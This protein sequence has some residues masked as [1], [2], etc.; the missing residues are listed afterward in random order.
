MAIISAS[1]SS[2]SPISASVTGGGGVVYTSTGSGSSPISV[3]VQGGAQSASSS[4]ESSSTPKQSYVIAPEKP[5]GMIYFSTR[6]ETGTFGMAVR[7]S[8]GYVAVMWWDG[9]TNTYGTGAASSYFL[10]TKIVPTTSFYARSA[11]K[12]VYVWPTTSASLIQYGSITGFS[13]PGRK[14][15]AMSLAD[16]TAL[17]ALTVD[18]NLMEHLDLTR[19]SAISS[20]AC[21]GNRLRSLDIT[22]CT[23]LVSLYCQNNLLSYLDVTLATGLL[24]LQCNDNQIGSLNLTYSTLLAELF[25]YNNLLTSLTIAGSPFLASL[26][27]SGNRLTTLRA[28]GISLDSTYGANIENNLLS[29]SAL[30]QFY[31]DLAVGGDAPIYVA[32]NIGTTSDDPSIATGRGYQVYGT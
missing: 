8:T 14:I 17:T 23:G 1:V 11:P 18:S 29:A 20:L 21:Y 25:V 27:C 15:T 13:C 22:T 19:C 31:S 30:N 24:T 2:G 28:I 6:L 9:T 7:S 26:N 5:P 3:S 32:G 10:I 4:G 12:S 16:C